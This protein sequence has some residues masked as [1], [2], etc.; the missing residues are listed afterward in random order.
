MNFAGTLQYS[1]L[2]RKYSLI[3]CD[4]SIRTKNEFLKGF[5]K[6][7]KGIQEY[8]YKKYKSKY[9]SSNKDNP[10]GSILNILLCIEENNVLRKVINYCNNNA[11]T[12]SS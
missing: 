2:L 3:N 10:K 8:F 4:K 6:E 1:L 5:D 9:N 7:M 11:F 12:F